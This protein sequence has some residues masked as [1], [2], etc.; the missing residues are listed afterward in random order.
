MPSERKRGKSMKF[1]LKI[2]TTPSDRSLS[3]EPLVTGTKWGG[4]HRIVFIVLLLLLNS[5]LC[6]QA[7]GQQSKTLNLSKAVIVQS[8]D[9]LKQRKAAEFLQ[10]EVEK[11]T[12]IHLAI[13]NSLPADESP[14]IVLGT[15]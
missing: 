2:A 5:G 12:G 10:S 4:A 15:V 1:K 13:S 7:Y 14:A 8:G 6:C 9:Q 11:R 3:G